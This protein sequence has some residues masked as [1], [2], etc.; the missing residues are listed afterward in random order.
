MSLE[1][2]ANLGEFVG[3]IVVVIS[4]VYVALQVRQNSEQLERT[5]QTIRTQTNQHQ[6]ED[7]NFYR[8]LLTDPK[9]AA[10]YVRG[11]ED[12]KSLEP[13]ERVQFNM[14]ASSYIWTG[15]YFYQLQKNEGLVGDPNSRVYVDMF[16]H[17]GFREWYSSYKDT[18]GEEYG[19]FLI[20][21]MNKVG[22]E[23]Y[24]EGEVS[25]LLQGRLE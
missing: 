15:W 22:E 7:F 1:Q 21:V 25:N 18:V 6:V 9:L 12:Y 11:L 8:Q 10:V 19:D 17:P 5:V 2:L 20:E 4:V 13:P 14:V 16:K 23:N 3:G 24:R